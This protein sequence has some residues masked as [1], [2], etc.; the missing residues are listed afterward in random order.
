MMNESEMFLDDLIKD[1]QKRCN[2]IEA[3]IGSYEMN[4]EMKIKIIDLLINDL[5]KKCAFFD[6]FLHRPK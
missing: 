6:N 3:I 4:C 5:C 1:V 2:C